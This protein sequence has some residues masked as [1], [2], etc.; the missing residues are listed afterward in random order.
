MNLANMAARLPA[1]AATTLPD[2][3]LAARVA[4][5][6]KGDSFSASDVQIV[7]AVDRP[8][9]AGATVNFKPGT[10]RAR[11]RDRQDEARI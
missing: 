6:A 10:N 1:Y 7:Q 3:L 4:L 2:K 5:L 8:G 11:D 9:L